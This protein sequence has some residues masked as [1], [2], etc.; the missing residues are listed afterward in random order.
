[1]IILSV[2]LLLVVLLVAGG[3]AFSRYQAGEIVRAHPNRGERIDIGAGMT[4]NSVLV[5]ASATAD[6]PPIVFIHGASGNLLDQMTPFRAPLEGRAEMLFVDRPGHG[7]SDRGGPENAFPDGQADAIARLMDKRGIKQAIIVGHSFGCAI[8]AS[9]ALNHKDK[10]LG[11]VFLSPA[12][13][14]WPGGVA[15]YNTV[16]RAPYI[17]WLFSN[18]VAVPVGLASIDAGTRSVFAPNHRPDDYVENTAPQLLLRPATFR[19]N[20]TDIANLN[21][22]VL[23]VSPRYPEIKAPTV[24]ITGDRDDIV[25]PEIHS[26]GLKRDIEGSVLVRIHNLGHKPDYIV[27]DVA[28]AAIETVAGK[29]VDLEATALA[30]ESRIAGN[31]VRP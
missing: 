25:L 20:A 31:D 10:V 30:A 7:Y 2:C 4:M 15:W 14:P 18:V 21:D 19:N 3:L 5:P 8:T 24:I 17:G 28:I 9:F 16:A 13:H 6:L 22:Y 11:L 12:T 23:R 29:P 27:T 26:A 1:M